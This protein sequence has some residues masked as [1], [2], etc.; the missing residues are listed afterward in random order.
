MSALSPRASRRFSQARKSRST[1]P[2]AS[3]SQ[4][5]ATAEPSGAFRLRLHE[6]HGRT[7]CRLYHET[8]NSTADKP[9]PHE[10]DSNAGAPGVIRHPAASEEDHE[11]DHD[12]CGNTRATTFRW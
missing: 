2:P 12:L 11:H 8:D 4:P 6:P 3:I 1:T 10:V 9:V 5:P 7:A